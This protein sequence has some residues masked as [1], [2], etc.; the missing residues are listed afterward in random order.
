MPNGSTRSVLDL[1]PF[2][3]RVARASGARLIDVDGFEY[4]DLLGDYSAGLLGHDPD[5]IGDALRAVLDRG[6]SYGGMHTAEVELAETLVRRF[7]SIDQVRFTN[8]GTE[9]NLIAIQLARYRTGRDRIVAMDGAYHGSLLSFGAAGRGLLAPY[10]VRRVTFNDVDSLVAVDDRVAAVLVEPMMGAAGCIPATPEFLHALRERTASVGSLLV[11]DEVMTSRMSIGGL[12]ALL[13][14]QPDLTTLG[15][16]LGGGLSFGAFGGRADVMAALDP[17][18][19]GTLAHGG[20]FNNN[21]FTMAA[22][23]AV[24]KMLDGAV[25]DAHFARGESLRGQLAEVLDRCSL[26]LSVTGV[27]SLMTL[28]ARRGPISTPSDL[29]AAD[30]T[31]GELLFHELLE[32]GVYT[33]RRGYVALSLA[34]DDA[35]CARVVDAL[36]EAVRAI[37]RP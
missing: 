28:H 8:S 7:A 29:D 17:V 33:A 34:V 22:G 2:P 4:L 32:R 20:T 10:D 26:P 37:E 14:V 12:Q 15:K 35:D 3:F 23:L 31:L 1:S 25:L 19:G 36:E 13:G 27:G 18:V 30:A 16:Y 21:A 9:A 5:P 11:F 6:W 24:A